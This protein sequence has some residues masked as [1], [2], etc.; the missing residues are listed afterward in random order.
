MRAEKYTLRI[1]EPKALGFS[2][3][4]DAEADYQ[5]MK[6]NVME[7]VRRLFRPEFLNRIDEIIVF[8]SLTRD[9]ISRILDLQ[10]S[11]IERRL[12]DT[13]RLSIELDESARSYF[14]TKGY[15]PKYGAR[16]LK[17]LLQNELEDLLAEEILK[18]NINDGDTVTASE[19]S[20]RIVLA[21]VRKE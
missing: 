6:N 1:V 5:R 11:D 21:A 17:R 10:L 15:Q 9:D 12:A 4:N 13:H 20:G 18:G 7:E 16:P 19:Q 14:I 2:A 8:H 3:A